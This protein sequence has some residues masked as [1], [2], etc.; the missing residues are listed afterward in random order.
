MKIYALG[1]VR[2]NCTTNTTEI[3]P[4]DNTT[5]DDSIFDNVTNQTTSE[6]NPAAVTTAA[7]SISTIILAVF[8]TFFVMVCCLCIGCILF[9]KRPQFKKKLRVPIHNLTKKMNKVD[10][11]VDVEDDQDSDDEE[12]NIGLPKEDDSKTTKGAGD[13]SNK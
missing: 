9:F 5:F 3:V 8:V 11:L 12:N 6:I 13:Q 10:V 7:I 4:V 1:F 2:L